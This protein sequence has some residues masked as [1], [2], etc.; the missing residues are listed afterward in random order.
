MKLKLSIVLFLCSFSIMAQKTITGTV[1]DEENIPLPGVNVIIKDSNVGVVTDFDGNYSIEASESDILEFSYLGFAAQSFQVGDKININVTM[2]ADNEMLDQVVVIGY[3]TTSKKDL[4]SS[5]SS[6]KAEVLENQPVS[7]VDQALQGRAAGVEVTSNDGAPGSGS[8]IRIRGNSSINGNNDPLFVVDGFIVGTGFNL[9]NL[10]INDIASIEVLKDATALAIYGTRGASGVVIITTKD[11]KGQ[12][13]GKPT[14]TVNSY[15]SLDNLANKIDILGGEQYIDYINEAAQFV[16]G[17]P[18]DFNG[19]SLQLGMRDTS[20]P[21]IYENPSEVPTTDWIDVVSQLGVTHNLDV[22]I[23]GNSKNTN[24]YTSLNYFNQKGI[25][26]GS[27]IERVVFRSNLD[28]DISDRFKAGFRLNLTGQKKENNKVGFGGIVSGVV[29]T[30]TIYDEEGNFTGIHPVTGSL[31]RNPEADIQLRVDHDLVTNII[32]NSFFEYELFTDFK[33]KSTLGI[34]QNFYKSNQYLPGLLPERLLNNNRGGFADI[35]TNQSKDILNENTFTYKK[36]L[37]KHSL[38]LLGGFTWQK[39]VSESTSSSADGFPNDVVEYN[40]LSL[41]SDPD[42]YEVN[43]GYNQRTLVSFLGRLTY[44]YDSRYVLTLVGRQDGS[45]V[46]EKGNKYSFF[47]SAG[48]AWNIDEEDFM[49]NVSA[50]NRLKLRASFGKVGE[51]GVNAYNSFDIF[52]SQFNY[53]NENLYPAIILSGP[54]SEDLQ[55]ETTEQLDLGIEIGLLKNR[56]SFEADY[57]QK[58]TNDLLLFRDLPNTAGN[59][60]LENVGSVEN[61]GFELLLNTINIDKENFQWSSTLTV[62][63]NRSKV[64]DLGAEEFINIQS[65]GNQGGSSA[66]LIVGQ[67]MPVFFGAEYLGTY[68]DPQEIIDDGTQGRSFLGSPRFRDVDGNGTINTA[69]YSVIGSPEADFYGGFRNSFTYKNIN[70]DVFFHGSYG[71]DIFN[72][73]SQTSFYGRGDENL[74]NRV[75]DR[76]VEGENELS[77]V[78]RAGTSTSLFNPNSTLNV[79][80]GSYLRLKQ[81][82]LSY[83][84]PVDKM[85]LGNT[86]KSINI[87]ASGR[88]LAL[89]SKFRLGDPEVNNFSA[90]SGFNSVSQG[91][92]SGQYPYSRSIVTGIKVEF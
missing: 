59:R 10:N 74:D 13:I 29:P 6:V 18:V 81:V 89:W 68:K 26:R 70:L 14:I 51:Q 90:G 21:L 60:I 4:V 41:G 17:D 40:N 24:Y 28:Y 50:I 20:L 85:N 42:S 84:I 39:I 75:L 35:D 56:I 82:T 45:S 49:E 69:D 33:L 30:R 48:I 57:Y 65:T 62:S 53:F 3:G 83:D 87:Y 66:R 91:F 12:P 43:S 92:A 71:N 73:R 79:E 25:I 78:P 67:P 11:G 32:A 23:M 88:N 8:T 64:L 86:F 54:G 34:T 2:A 58:T 27:G 44:S 72:V 19:T 5:V 36:D 22:S 46:F 9:N 31:Q 61:K 77:N 7:R 37:G 15:V 63:Q 76:Y 47:P 16:P 38:N 80:D 52:N 1:T 55:W